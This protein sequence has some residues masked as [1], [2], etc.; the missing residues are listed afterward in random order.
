MLAQG[1]Q[2]ATKIL[3]LHPP[4]FLQSIQLLAGHYIAA[5]VGIYEQVKIQLQQGA[6][7][8]TLGMLHGGE[9]TEGTCTRPDRLD[10]RRLGSGRG[11][12]GVARHNTVSV[13]VQRQTSTRHVRARH[14]FSS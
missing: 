4:A 11:V 14:C 10:A 5:T 3:A 2:R 13:D 9:V 12:P 6:G 1:K 7:S 8:Q